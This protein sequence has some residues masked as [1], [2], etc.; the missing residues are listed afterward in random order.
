LRNAADPGVVVAVGSIPAAAV[1][2]GAA[3]PLAV[4]DFAVA[5]A[6]VDIAVAASASR[7]VGLV[8]DMEEASGMEEAMDIAALD[9]AS[10]S[11]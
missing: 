10:D 1:D 3:V 9:T 11:A 8:V 2:S 4:V 6:L 7:A 5:A